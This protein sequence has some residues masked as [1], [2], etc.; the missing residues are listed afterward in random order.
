MYWQIEAFVYYQ[1]LLNLSK[2]V[3]ANEIV[4][5]RNVLSLH[6]LSHTF[7]RCCSHPY[8]FRWYDSSQYLQK[9]LNLRDINFHKKKLF[10]KGRHSVSKELLSLAV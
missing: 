1:I 9:A 2:F 7:V 4:R 8:S 3:L 6:T 5:F 10:V